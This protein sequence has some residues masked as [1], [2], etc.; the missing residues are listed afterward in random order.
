MECEP[1][2]TF[3]MKRPLSRMPLTLTLVGAVAFGGLSQQPR[4]WQDPSPHITQFVTVDKNVRL[5]VLDWGGSGRP[6]VLLAGGGDTP[7]AFDDFA[8]QPT[9]RLPVYRIPRRGVRATRFFPRG[10]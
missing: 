5:E 4:T 9:P 1:R 6:L 7:H 3:G 10:F 8:P 2:R